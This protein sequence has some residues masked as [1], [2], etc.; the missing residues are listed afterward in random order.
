MKPI[1]KCLNNFGCQAFML[2][3]YG[4]LIASRQ[5]VI[6]LINRGDLYQNFLNCLFIVRCEQLTPVH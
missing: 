4:T 2:L 6:L 1:T 5:F 3:T